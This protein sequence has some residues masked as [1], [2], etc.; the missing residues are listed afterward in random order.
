M[1]LINPDKLISCIP[2]TLEF[3]VKGQII[4]EKSR[5]TPFWATDNTFANDAIVAGLTSRL[6]VDKQSTTKLWEHYKNAH[7]FNDKQISTIEQR[8]ALAFASSY[9][10][11]AR[12]W[13]KQSDPHFTNLAVTEWRIRSDLQQT[14]WND[15]IMSIQN[16]PAESQQ[17]PR[18]QYWKAS[19]LTQAGNSRKTAKEAFDIDFKNPLPTSPPHYDFRSIYAHH[20]QPETPYLYSKEEILADLKT[21]VSER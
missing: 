6:K 15:V 7:H 8:I 3:F 16:L 21:L 9:T 11:E 1:K 20:W 5:L 10:P 19:A 2:R 13:L 17:E 14:D 12:T 4:I 18:W